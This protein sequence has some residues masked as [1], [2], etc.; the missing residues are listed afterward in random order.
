MGTALDQKT[1]ARLRRSNWLRGGGKLTGSSSSSLD[2][3]WIDVISDSCNVAADKSVERS[4]RDF[5]DND[6]DDDGMV[7]PS[8]INDC[9]PNAR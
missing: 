3:G 2:A 9:V 8:V 1:A 6:D 4:A 7:Y 5:V